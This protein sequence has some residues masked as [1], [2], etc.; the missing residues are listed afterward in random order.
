MVTLGFNIVSGCFNVW[1]YDG[2]RFYTYFGVIIYYSLA[3]F[4]MYYDSLSFRSIGNSDGE[5][6]YFAAGI[7][8]MVNNARDQV[9]AN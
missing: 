3:V 1:L 5:N 8:H 7:R 6:F 2:A 9:R 4:K